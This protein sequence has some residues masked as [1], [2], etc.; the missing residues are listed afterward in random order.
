MS[1]TQVL[2]SKIA[3]LRQRLDQ[4]QGLIKDAGSA[5]AS[6]LDGGSDPVGVLEGK[7]A[8]AE[9]TPK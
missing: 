8:A 3:A 5:A 1:D 4:A 6:L 2:L 7:L 9:L